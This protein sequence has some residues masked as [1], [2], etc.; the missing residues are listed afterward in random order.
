MSKEQSGPIPPVAADGQSLE[1]HGLGPNTQPVAAV[2]HHATKASS[3]DRAYGRQV[4]YNR[5]Q[6]GHS[7]ILQFCVVGI[8]TLWI[9]PIYYAF[10]PNHYYHI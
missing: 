8:F 1:Y 6:K 5:Q 2:D 3:R 7:L 10:S 9:V 4:V